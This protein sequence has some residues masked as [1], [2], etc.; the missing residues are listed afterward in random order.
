[1]LAVSHKG[2]IRV[3]V[4]ALLGLDLSTYRSRLGLP[5]SAVTIFEFREGG[6]FLRAYGDTSHVP[7][8]LRH[9]L[10]M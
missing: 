7:L 2:T 5:A 4:C 8:H 9:D 6:P 1:M 3:L 10:G